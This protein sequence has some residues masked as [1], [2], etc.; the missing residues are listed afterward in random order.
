MGEPIC[1]PFSDEQWYQMCSANMSRPVPLHKA[2]LYK[3][4]VYDRQWGLFYVSMGFHYMAMAT[5]LTFRAG[6]VDPYEYKRSLNLEGY[7]YLHQM[8]DKWLLEVEGT[9]FASSLDEETI[10]VGKRGNLNAAEKQA[11]RKHPLRYIEDKS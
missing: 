4:F 3:P 9:A 1:D 6:F 2:E 10:T 5:L 11:M 7:D 8:A